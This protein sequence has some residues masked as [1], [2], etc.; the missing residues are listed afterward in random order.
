MKRALTHDE[1]AVSSKIAN[2]LMPISEKIVEFCNEI[3]E[4]VPADEWSLPTFMDM[5]FIR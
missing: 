5:L 1:V 4:I 2:E 3:E